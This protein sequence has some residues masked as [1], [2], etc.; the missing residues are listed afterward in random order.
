MGL[1]LRILLFVFAVALGAVGAF[2]ALRPAPRPLPDPPAL[3][4]QMREVARLET[5]EVS[6]YKK[7]TFSPEPAGSDALWK[8][9]INWAAYSIRTPRGRAIVFADVHLGYDF[10]RIDTSSLR[11]SGSRVDVVLPPLEVKVELRP[12]ETEVIDSNLNSQETAHLLERARVAFEKEVRADPRL[13]ERARLSAERSLRALFL[14]VGFTEVRFVDRL[15][16]ASAG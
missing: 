4:T 16:Q 7:V 2:F 10:Q 14:T 13:K 12:G 1:V 9:V 3:V 6:L 11:V 8:D 15:T 5:L